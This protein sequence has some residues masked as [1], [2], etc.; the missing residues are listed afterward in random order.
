MLVCPNKNTTEWKDLVATV[1]E[2]EAFRDFIESG[3]N[4]RDPKVVSEKLI[5]RGITTTSGIENQEPA[6]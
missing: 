1:G 6:R 4:I 3:Y 5:E 2:F